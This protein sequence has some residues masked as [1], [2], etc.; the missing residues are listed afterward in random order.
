[1]KRSYEDN[2][3]ELCN[4][5]E[6]A[7]DNG[8]LYIDTDDNA[9]VLINNNDT[10]RI[11]ADGVVTRN[12]IV[13]RA[14]INKSNRRSYTGLLLDD[15]DVRTLANYD[16]LVAVE[17]ILIE[18]HRDRYELF[19][20]G[21]TT[22]N[23]HPRHVRCL[24]NHING[25]SLDDRSENL[26]VVSAGMNNAHSRLMAEVHY[27]FP[28]LVNEMVDCQGNKM[29]SWVDG[30]GISCDNIQKWN[31]LHP[32]CIIKAFKDKKGSWTPR[33]SYEQILEILIYFGKVE[34]LDEA[35]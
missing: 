30:V 9:Y 4:T 17:G 15:G 27:Y 13:S 7:Y 33:M 32:E 1:M 14:G 35:S 19:R 21:L 11:Y 2:K 5:L 16:I 34:V 25:D 3:A 10:I 20:D 6:R 8:E 31:R 29:H 12:G 23:G 24:V 22:Y 26:E 28:H 18:E